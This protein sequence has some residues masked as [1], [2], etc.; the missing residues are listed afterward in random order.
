MI[1]CGLASLQIAVD[2]WD[3][4]IYLWGLCIKE[5]LEDSHTPLSLV[6]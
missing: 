3:R 5:L 6:L 1:V 4:C 2:T